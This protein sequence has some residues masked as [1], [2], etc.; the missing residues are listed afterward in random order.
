MQT[1]HLNQVPELVVARN[2][3]YIFP[4]PNSFAFIY[5]NTSEF[6]LVCRVRKYKGNEK[7]WE[8]VKAYLVLPLAV[9]TAVAD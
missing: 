9:P 2:L 5:P 4:S 8:G 1:A 3:V 7:P 6:L